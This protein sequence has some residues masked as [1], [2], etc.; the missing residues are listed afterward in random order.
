M[1]TTS[2]RPTATR[3]R[4]G[5]KPT[6]P[7]RCTRAGTCSRACATLRRTR[8]ARDSPPVRESIPGR[9]T[10][11]TRSVRTTLSSRR[12]R[13][14][15]RSGARRLSAARPTRRSSWG[16]ANGSLQFHAG[17]P[18]HFRPE[19]VVALD[20]RGKLPG[21]AAPR[22]ASRGEQALLHFRRRE[23]GR[24]IAL[25]ARDQRRRH[26]GRPEQRVPEIEFV[27]LQAPLRGRRHAQPG[28]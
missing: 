12:T 6:T 9:A 18:D 2:R 4:Y 23:D 1:R 17:R 13:I 24:D 22:V 26:S 28:G 15:V 3:T 10:A 8:Y 11:P 5:R 20:T 27:A 14:T 25:D 19:L 16:P 7:H 21:P